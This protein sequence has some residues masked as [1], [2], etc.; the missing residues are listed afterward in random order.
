MSRI[1]VSIGFALVIVLAPFACG[2]VQAQTTSFAFQGRLTDG[3]SGA[4]GNYDLQFSLFDSASGGTQ[5]GSTLSRNNTPVTAGAF[6][7]QLDFGVIAFPGAARFLE[8]GVK[9]P[10][11]PGFTTLQPRQAVRSTPYS[12]RTLSS[13]QADSLSSVCNGCILDTHINAIAG[14]KITGPVPATSLPPGLGVGWQMVAGTTQQAA[15][16]TNYVVTS[17]SEATITLPAAA[18]VGDTIRVSGAGGGG[19]R[20][21]Q[22]DGQTVI[23]DNIGLIANWVPHETTRDWRAVAS[24]A[25]GTKLVAVVGGAG[26]LI[27][28]SP[29]AGTT[30]FP[31]ESIRP[32]A[33]VASSADGTKLVAVPNGGG[34][35]YTSTDSG[36]TWTPRENVRG[37][38]SV[39]S[40]AD[41]TVLVA[42]ADV[43]YV[44]TDSGVSWTPHE[45]N[46]NWQAVAC[47][48][49]GSK[50]VAVVQAGRIYTSTDFGVN[51]T[52]REATRNWWA[53]ASS[54]DGNKLVA[55]VFGGQI[56]TST[57]AG[58]NWTA[59]ES[60]R[61]WISV[62]SS[63]DGV[64]LVALESPGVTHSSSDSGVNWS[65]WGA[66]KTWGAIAAS[67]DL[68]RLLA[69]GGAP[70]LALLLHTS[71][72][73]TT[74]G[75]GGALIG[76]PSSA[77]ELQYIGN[78]RFK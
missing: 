77:I 19:W 22:N 6:T 35:I 57:D 41:G 60:V 55:A 23:G 14:S 45:S 12:I 53:V 17:D 78:G 2:R 10:A 40:S 46:R 37:W 36:Q 42:T 3:G 39:A 56:Y 62:V 65:A 48:T 64:K 27:Y 49:D 16:N 50:M 15:A 63:S 33:G 13:A 8:I 47:S 74:P 25:D 75:S 69:A 20:I 11:S 52:P 54:A 66:S 32:W 1:K 29:D 26:G 58:V 28:T 21:A 51:W 9:L 4:N 18:N 61:N 34:Q 30:W 73:N 31:H 72:P 43:L 76:A 67:T 68:S 70:N 38:L 59:R 7:V 24:S 71:S 5:I 44:S